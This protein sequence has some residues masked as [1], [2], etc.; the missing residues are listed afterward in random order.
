M[1]IFLSNKYVGMIKYQ[2]QGEFFEMVK[3]EPHVVLVYTSGAGLQLEWPGQVG[4][5][6]HVDFAP[7]WLV[8][9][10]AAS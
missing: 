9:V 2:L 7:S 3:D 8:S 5:A 6:P 4:S 10:A 1:E